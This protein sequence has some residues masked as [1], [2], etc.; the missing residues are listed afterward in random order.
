MLAVGTKASHASSLADV[1]VEGDLRGHYSHGLNRMDLYVKETR[2]GICAKE[3]EPVV[4]KESVATALVNGKNLLGP[5]V[6]NFCMSLAM[7][8]AQDVGIGWVVAYS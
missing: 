4:E 7:K 3:G 8:K 6:G 5:V 2:A 1:L